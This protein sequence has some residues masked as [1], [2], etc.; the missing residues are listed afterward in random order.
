MYKTFQKD[1]KKYY[2]DPSLYQLHKEGP[3]KS[4]FGMDNSAG[5][6]DGGFGLY[7]S[8][9][10]KKR[11]GPVKTEYFRI[12]LVCS[13]TVNVDIGL[14]TFQPVRNGIILGFPGQVFSLYDPGPDFCCYY[15]LFTEEFIGNELL[16]NNDIEF[17][18]FSYS[19]I[20]CF[21]LTEEDAAEAENTIL[22]IND[23]IK[24]RKPG[25]RR[26]IQLYLH[27][28][29]LQ[30]KRSYET[31][32]LFKEE[33]SAS[34]NNLFRKFIRLVSRHFLTHRKVADYAA[35][36]NVSADHLGRTIK[37]C[38]DKT[39]HE[40]IDDMLLTEA[41]AYLRHSG[42][43]VSEISYKLEFSDPSYFNKFFK[44]LTGQTPQ[45]YRSIPD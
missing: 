35:L 38:S 43:S 17:P 28:I 12:G 22:K 6:L 25:T 44:K 4:D 24:N 15:M 39:A 32:Q 33:T 8:A 21:S 23:E 13:G 2:L 1:I 26:A 16:V 37:S 30:A 19:G 7:S 42:L 27:L 29:L 41:K 5:L 34:G 31:R 9:N 11:I 14:E 36:L 3:V 40:M 10:L 18:F 20:Q 45:Q